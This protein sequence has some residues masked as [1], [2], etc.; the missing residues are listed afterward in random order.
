MIISEISKKKIIFLAL[1]CLFM[2][3]FT[4]FPK[5][6]DAEII[7]AFLFTP[8]GG[9][10][11][12]ITPCIFPHG[13]AIEIIPQPKVIGPQQLQTLLYFPNAV[14]PIPISVPPTEVGQSVMGL[15]TIP[16]VCIG[17]NFKA[18]KG[19]HVFTI[20]SAHIKGWFGI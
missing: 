6:T 14:S 12:L 1:I 10:V 5:K 19:L 20:N 11:Y 9:W 7:P 4:A 13:L 16:F 2:V 18:I 17:P 8:F 3:F 15:G